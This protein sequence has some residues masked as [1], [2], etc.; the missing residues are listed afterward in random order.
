MMTA[1]K[2]TA[3]PNPIA[4]HGPETYHV[5]LSDR[6]SGQIVTP[7]VRAWRKGR[8][9]YLVQLSFFDSSDNSF[10]DPEETCGDFWSCTRWLA[11]CGVHADIDAA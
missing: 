5:S 11:A 10:A 7:V 4:T 1:T 2:L 8:K 9:H 6:H 3:L